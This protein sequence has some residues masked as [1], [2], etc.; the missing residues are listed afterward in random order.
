VG[1]GAGWGERSEGKRPKTKDGGKEKKKKKNE[2]KN[3]IKS[4]VG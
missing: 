3:M 1:R 2:R 4:K